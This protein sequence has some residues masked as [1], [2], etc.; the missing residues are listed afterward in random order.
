MGGGSKH[1]GGV[2]G[3]SSP[4][5]HSGIARVKSKLNSPRVLE[6]NSPTVDRGREPE[7]INAGEHHDNALQDTAMLYR[8]AF[9]SCHSDR[10]VTKTS[11]VIC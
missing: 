6:V 2:A 1:P 5:P 8:N 9:I 10:R 3:T 11:L 7:A 4:S